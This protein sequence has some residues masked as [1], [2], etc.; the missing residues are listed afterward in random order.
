MPFH[1]LPTNFADEISRLDPIADPVDV[2]QAWV[3]ARRHIGKLDLARGLECAARQ[4]DRGR[5]G[6]AGDA[7]R[8]TGRKRQT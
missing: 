3:V 1:P 4:G 7:H 2:D 8:A 5:N 6:S